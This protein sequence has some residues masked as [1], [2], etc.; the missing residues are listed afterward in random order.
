MLLSHTEPQEH[1]EAIPHPSSGPVQLL[2]HG[3]DSPN[4]RGAQGMPHCQEDPHTPVKVLGTYL[5]SL[6]PLHALVG[7]KAKSFHEG[8]LAE[9]KVWQRA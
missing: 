2:G 3:E 9:G 5:A 7:S 6:P 4:R 8:L 1:S